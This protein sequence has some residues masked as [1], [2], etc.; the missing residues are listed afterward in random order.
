MVNRAEAD[1]APDGS[2]RIEIESD[3]APGEEYAPTRTTLR[4]KRIA[5]VG[6]GKDEE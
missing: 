4:G 6:L 2:V 1:I 5:P 3:P